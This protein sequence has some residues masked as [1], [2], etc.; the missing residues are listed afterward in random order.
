MTSPAT[1]DDEALEGS[2]YVNPHDASSRWY[3]VAR[4]FALRQG[5]NLGYSL[6]HMAAPG[7]PGTTKTIWLDSTIG[8]YRGKELIKVDI[9]VPYPKRVLRKRPAVINLHGGG[10]V[11]GQGTDD[12]RWAAAVVKDL[13]AIVFSV[14][15]R[16][17]PAYHF[18]KPVED[19][20][21]AILQ[22][23]SRAEEFNF[24][25]SSLIISGFSAGGNLALASWLVLQQPER[26]NYHLKLP[27]PNVLAFSLFYPLL[28]CT[29]SRP[30]KRTR[31]VRPDMTLPSSLTDLFD[32]S[33]IYPPLAR[34]ERNDL[35]LSP[36]LMPDEMLDRMPPLH[37]CLCEWDMLLPEGLTFAERLN[38]RKKQIV[39]RVVAQEKHAWDKPPPVQ[40]KKSMGIEYGEAIKTLK[41]CIEHTAGPLRRV[42]PIS[43]LVRANTET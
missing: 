24:D 5:A 27:V 31:C 38:S 36:G 37:L 22:I 10:F 39:V 34:E 3:L 16:L 28:D 19:C 2:E 29:V 1:P 32:A 9:W 25:P 20:V 41:G 7:A 15:Y 30:R 6:Q 43:T 26:W 23:A 12:T 42:R 13:D 33:Y 8:K 18:P 17:A 40:P 35:R 14:N 21:D 11:L 4:V